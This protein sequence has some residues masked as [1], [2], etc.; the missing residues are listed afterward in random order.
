MKK[1]NSIAPEDCSLAAVV[2]PEDLCCGDYVAVLNEVA[3]LPSFFW[4]DTPTSERHEPVRMRCLPSKGGAPLKIKAICLPF[5]FVKSPS[6]K[7]ETLDIRRTQL[8]RLDKRYGKTVW[9]ALG[10]QPRA[11]PKLESGD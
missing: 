5:V 7:G 10:K 11:A 4:C 9:K 6:G 3:E 2:A 8:A 1:A